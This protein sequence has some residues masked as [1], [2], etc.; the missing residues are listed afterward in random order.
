MFDK[1][2][3]IGTGGTGGYLIPPLVKT[4]QYHPATRDNM[5]TIIDGDDFENKNQSR[6]FMTPDHVGQNKADAMA[7]MCSAMG[8]TNVNAFGEY[9]TMSSF[10]PFLE[11]SDSPL[12]IAAVDNDA[13]RAAVID[14]IQLTCAGKDFFFITP[15]NSDGIEEVHGQ[16]LWFG[17]ING[18]NVGM[19]PKDVFPNIIQP[20]DEIPHAGSCARLQESRPQL[21]SANFMAAAATLAVIQNLL[22]EKLEANKSGIY[23][24][25][26]NLKTSVS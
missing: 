22:D 3:V 7:E 16:T 10:I 18:E 8:L 5:V 6:Q 11:E 1:T 26:R 9:I 2:F 13:T 23:F 4:L 21:I 15:G 14:A 12:I 20:E 24:N 19:N 25:I 17:R